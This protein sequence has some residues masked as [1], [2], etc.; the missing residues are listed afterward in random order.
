MRNRKMRSLLEKPLFI[1][2]CLSLCGLVTLPAHAKETFTPDHVAKVRSVGS[3]KISPDGEHVAYVLTVPRRPHKDDNGPAWAELHV[4]DMNGQSRPFVTGEVNVS[5]V[6]WTPDGSGI[7]FLAK[8][9][10]DEHKGLYLIPINGGEAR[11]IVDHETDISSYDWSPDGQ[12]VAFLAKEKKDKDLKKLQDKGFDAEIYE[13]DWRHA[14]VWTVVADDEE[15][16]PEAMDLPGTASVVLWNPSGG[17]FAVSLAPTPL[18]DDS[19]M[20]RRIHIVE[21]ETGDIVT[22]IDNPG[23]LGSMKWSPDGKTLAVI[24]AE[25]LNDPSAGRLM[26]RTASD[27]K[28]RDLVPNYKGQFESIAWRD[29]NTIMYLS[30]EGC[31]TTFGRVGADGSNHE[32]IVSA[33]EG[34]VLHGLSL[35]KDGQTA[36]YTG[37]S[38]THPNEVFVMK[39]GESKP[40]RLTDSNP[41]LSEM[42]FAKQT[43]GKYK[44]RD[45]LEVQGILVE[46]L[47]KKSDQRYP[48]I[49]TVHGGPESHIPNGWVTR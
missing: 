16:E 31:H 10:D 14:K 34:P 19:Y 1:A 24:S 26:V 30:S 22:R 32:T 33:D 44:A 12:R 5:S 7:S 27:T 37:E 36:A 46:P 11:K 8:R 23:K 28:L 4:V 45:G 3:A 47:D 40:R 9:N 17:Q 6:H 15:A 25:D 29:N 35:S 13:E 42:R 49:L 48:L 21:T 2:F 20:A 18:V 39:H 43:V 38:P 41:W